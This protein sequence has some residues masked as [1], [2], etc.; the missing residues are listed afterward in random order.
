MTDTTALSLPP[1][2]DLDIVRGMALSMTKNDVGGKFETFCKFFFP[3][4]DDFV[5]KYWIFASNFLLIYQLLIYQL[6]I[7][8]II[9]VHS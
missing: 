1:K 3:V 7:Y 4:A 2:I 8:Q 9:I 6:L 5:A